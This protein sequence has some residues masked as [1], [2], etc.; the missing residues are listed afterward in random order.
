MTNQKMK[1]DG[2][3]L[4]SFIYRFTS[5]SNSPCKKS[6]HDEHFSVT[7]LR[8]AAAD[9]VTRP[10]TCQIRRMHPGKL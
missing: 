1:L 6:S 8:A 10:L 2:G 5:L 3:Q 9:L 7:W 4:S